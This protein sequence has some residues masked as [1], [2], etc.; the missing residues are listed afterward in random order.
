MTTKGLPHRTNLWEYILN[1]I[2]LAMESVIP[3]MLATFKVGEL[4]ENIYSTLNL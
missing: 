3:L 2:S 4:S 1:F